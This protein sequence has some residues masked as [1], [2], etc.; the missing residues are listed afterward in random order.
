MSK[1]E[2]EFNLEQYMKLE[3]AL[4]KDF[5]ALIDFNNNPSSNPFGTIM[6]VYKL[7]NKA[8]IKIK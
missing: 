6:S 4:G 1:K 7:L 3:R 2:N 5:D 8:N